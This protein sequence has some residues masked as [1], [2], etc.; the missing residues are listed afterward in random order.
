VLV[1]GGLKKLE[2]PQRFCGILCVSSTWNKAATEGFQVNHNLR[3]QIERRKQCNVERLDRWNL[4]D[5]SQP[6]LSA[7]NIHYELAVRAAGTTCGGIGAIHR[8]VRELGLAEAIDRR[9]HLLKVHLPYHE[10]DHV[11]NLAYN[12]LCG[13]TCLEDLE[14][15]RQDEALLDALGARRIPDPTTAGD[16]CRRFHPHHIQTLQDAFHDARR[17]VWA[18]QPKAFFAQATID[19][20]GTLVPTTGECKQGMDIAYNGVWGYHPLVVSLAN[21][22]EPLFILN[23]SASRPSYEGAA[24]YFDRAATLCREAGFR[25]IC[26]RGDTDFS[27]TTYLDRW[28]KDGVSFVFGLDAQPNLVARAEELLRGSVQAIA[29]AGQSIVLVSALEALAAVF[30]AQDRPRR[31]AGTGVPTRSSID[32]PRRARNSRGKSAV[33]TA[34]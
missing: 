25:H 13:G 4:G 15:R 2:I 14:L 8:L 3:R 30:S 18:R 21:T 6:V 29:V 28:D 16:F 23:R 22:Q 31:A 20:D 12:A 32:F 34:G 33:R 9:L 1:G 17:K 11:L 5:T 24:D 10:S 7:R 26:F 27:Q 19:M